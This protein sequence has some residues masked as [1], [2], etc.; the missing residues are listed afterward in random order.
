[1]DDE[2][3]SIS[4]DISGLETQTTNLEAGLSSASNLGYASIGIAVIVGAV[5][6]FMSRRET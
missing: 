5:A 3:S 4:S 2:L 6:I 1:L